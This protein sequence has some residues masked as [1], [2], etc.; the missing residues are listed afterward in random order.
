MARQTKAAL[1]TLLALGLVTLTAHPALAHEGPKGAEWIMA[2]WMFLSF[3]I[4]AGVAFILFLAALKRGLLTGLE[5]E[6][7]HYI[8]E[9]DEPDYYSSAWGQDDDREGRA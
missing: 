5:G 4:F 6:A 2:D 9:I 8:L 7:K 1:I 3:A